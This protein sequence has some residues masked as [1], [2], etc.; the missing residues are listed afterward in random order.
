MILWL[1]GQSGTGKSTLANEVMRII[2][3]AKR[4]NTLLVDGDVVREVWGGDLGYSEADR[5]VNMGRMSRLCRYFADQGVNAVAAVIAPFQETRDWN[6]Q[7]IQSYYEVFITAPHDDLVARD[8]KGLYL[9]ALAGET[10]L[11][12]I[13]QVYERPKQPDLIIENSGSLDQ[14]LNHAQSL[15]DLILKGREMVT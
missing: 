12:G 8:P 1:T 3:D 9:K 15:A 11:S 6:R 10:E 4:T 7:H 5:R 13:N 14:F 2:R